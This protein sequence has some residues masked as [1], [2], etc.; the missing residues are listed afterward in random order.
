[1]GKKKKRR[2][3]DEKP[4]P[5][6]KKAFVVQQYLYTVEEAKRREDERE[7]IQRRYELK[8]DRFDDYAITKY[9]KN[10]LAKKQRLMRGSVSDQVGEEKR[11]LGI[12]EEEK[13]AKKT[14]LEALESRKKLF[15]EG[16]EFKYQNFR[17]ADHAET[18]VYKASR[19]IEKV[20]KRI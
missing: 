18:E 1:M 13:A 3:P 16:K 7:G 4:P 6:Q 8:L 2:K 14:T 15:D 12:L 10:R 5:I 9:G 11:K 17:N 20:Q 19:D